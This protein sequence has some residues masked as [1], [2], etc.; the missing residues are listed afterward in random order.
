[1]LKSYLNRNG[2]NKFCN[3]IFD[4]ITRFFQG[5]NLSVENVLCNEAEQTESNS[6]EWDLHQQVSDIVIRDITVSF[7]WLI[8]FSFLESFAKVQ[9]NILIYFYTDEIEEEE[10]YTE[11][12]PSKVLIEDLSSRLKAKVIF[13]TGQTRQKINSRVI[14]F[15]GW[16]K[17][18]VRKLEKMLCQEQEKEYYLIGSFSPKYNNGL[19]FD[20]PHIN[21]SSHIIKLSPPFP[22]CKRN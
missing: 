12:V 17:N 4:Q 10:R 8:P 16:W 19:D 9:R 13:V 5:N 21:Q 11:V 7:G 18:F 22:F 1:M 6:R 14:S 15:Y 20:I 3:R 2:L